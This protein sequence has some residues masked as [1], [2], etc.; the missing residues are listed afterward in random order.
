MMGAR[1]Q[2]GDPSQRGGIISSLVA[3]IAA[4][5]LM[6]LLYLVR[7]PVFRLIGEAWVV[8]DTLVRADALI[9]LK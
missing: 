9:V 4:V 2:R 3:T 1:Q 5:F 7:H 6:F 8:E